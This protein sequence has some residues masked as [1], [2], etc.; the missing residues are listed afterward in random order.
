M[1]S[2]EFIREVNEE[3]QQDKLKALWNQYGAFVIAGAVAIVAATAGAVGWQNY[4]ES[5]MQ[6][7]GMLR[8]EAEA[9]LLAGD[10]A[11]AAERFAQIETDFGAGPGA[12]AAFGEAMALAEGGDSGEASQKLALL[13]EQDGID[14]ALASLAK[15]KSLQ[16]RLDD[17]DP[18]VLVSALEAL[19]APGQA[20]SLAARETL[21]LALI[22]AGETERAK[23][24]LISVIEDAFT[25]D[26]LQARATELLAAIGGRVP[27]AEEVAQ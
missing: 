2:D 24:T 14:P 9:A 22:R 25:S 21:A 4:Q 17:E 27:A 15:L 8:A 5:Q 26:S 10:H 3:L 23:E 13:A 1:K 19:A 6:A 7:Q 16:L 18:G 12:L 11:K 20:F